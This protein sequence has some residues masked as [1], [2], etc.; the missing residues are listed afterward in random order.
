MSLKTKFKVIHTLSR[1]KRCGSLHNTWAAPAVGQEE[2]GMGVGQ[3]VLGHSPRWAL[4]G[5]GKAGLGEEFRI[6]SFE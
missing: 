6:K 2:M 1:N 4:H 5:K 3:G